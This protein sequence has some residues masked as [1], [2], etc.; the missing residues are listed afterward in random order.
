MPEK[1]RI[2]IFTDLDGTL[3]DH[4]DYNWEAAR[5]ALQRIFEEE[6]P[7]IFCSSKTRQEMIYYRGL[8]GVLDPFV[9]ENGAA[10]YVPLGYFPRPVSSVQRGGYEVIE[11]GVPYATLR[12]FLE[13]ARERLGIDLRGFGDMEVGEIQQ[14]TA[15]PTHLAEF[16]KQREYNE[17]F[18]FVHPEDEARLGELEA[19]AREKNLRIT[20]GGRFFHLSGQHD[21]GMAVRRLVGLFR[22]HENVT[23][24]TIGVGD[25]PN[26]LDMLRAVD[27]PV[28]VKNSRGEYNAEVLR[29]IRPKLAPG[30]GPEGWNQAVLVLLDE[31]TAAS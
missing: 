4:F 27:I 11:L 12:A 30:P 8:M 5:P 21:K 13:E 17:P 10:I 18:Y 22:E 14:M 19:L 16:A 20:R 9:V 24:M 25:S 31:L 29:E 3:L 6:I 28:L 2:L 7:L 15:L 1:K 23:P 26:D